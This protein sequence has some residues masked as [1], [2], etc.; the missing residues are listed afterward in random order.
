MTKFWKITPRRGLILEIFDMSDGYSWD[1]RTRVLN[2]YSI[3][4]FFRTKELKSFWFMADGPPT[5][6]DK[7]INMNQKLLGASL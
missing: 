5:Y 6:L 7:A 4:S 3:N 2:P 1:G